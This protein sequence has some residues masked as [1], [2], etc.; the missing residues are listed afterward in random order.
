VVV[1]VWT[2]FKAVAPTWLLTELA[3]LTRVP[4]VE[5]VAVTLSRPA[6]LAVLVKLPLEVTVRSAPV[7]KAS[8]AVLLTVT[9]EPVVMALVVWL[10]F[11]PL[12]VVMALDCMFRAL[13]AVVLTA[14][15]LSRLPE[16]VVLEPVNCT[17]LPVKPV[18][19]PD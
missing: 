12:P 18:V 13:P 4:P 2:T 5:A 8:A 17:V 1:V 6:V 15:S 10:T 19:V 9:N 3:M 14:V 11:T 16:P 7:V